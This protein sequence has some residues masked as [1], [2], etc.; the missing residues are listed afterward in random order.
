VSEIDLANRVNR[1]SLGFNVAANSILIAGNTTL[2]F[3]LAAKFV[4]SVEVKF[5]G[6]KLEE[7]DLFALEDFY[8]QMD[9]RCKRKL[10]QVPFVYKALKVSSMEFIF[11]RESGARIDLDLKVINQILNIK[12]GVDWEIVNNY[13]LVVKTPKYIGYQMARFKK[14]DRTGQIEKIAWQTKRN[15]FWNFVALEPA[16]FMSMSYVP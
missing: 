13:I 8:P 1:F 16:E 12:A 7:V 6:A 9:E 5:D 15:G 14:A 3:N 4:K 10:D 11:K 2:S